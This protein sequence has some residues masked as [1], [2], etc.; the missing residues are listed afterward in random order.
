MLATLPRDFD[1][2]K[3]GL[4]GNLIPT[5]PKFLRVQRST[6]STH[7]KFY[8]TTLPKMEQN[9]HNMQQKWQLKF[10]EGNTSHAHNLPFEAT[11]KL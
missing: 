3:I 11:R 8:T 1:F 9:E 6:N 5:L 7:Y 4:A 2:R 10:L